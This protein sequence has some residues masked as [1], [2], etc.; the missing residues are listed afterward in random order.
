MG[1]GH[2]VLGFQ[3]A[4]PMTS[5]RARHSRSQELKIVATLM[6]MRN[7]WSQALIGM[8]HFCPHEFS[9]VLMSILICHSWSHVFKMVAMLIGMKVPGVLKGVYLDRDEA[10]LLAGIEKVWIVIGMRLSWHQDFEN[11]S[12]LKRMHH[13]LTQD[14]I[15]FK[16]FSALIGRSSKC[17]DVDRDEKHLVPGVQKIS[18]LIGQ[19][20]S[21]SHGVQK[22]VDVNEILITS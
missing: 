19:R 4:K 16:K 10:F 1:M 8:R 14:F 21:L 13:S 11:A 17:V 3:K 9:K 22:G 15:E 6:R 20:H 2:L 18:T 12:T 7:S 5:I